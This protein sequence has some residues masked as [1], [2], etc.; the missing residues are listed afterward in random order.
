MGQRLTRR[1]QRVL[2]GGVR[3][4]VRGGHPPRDRGDVDDAPRSPLPHGRQHRLDH[5]DRAPVVGLEHRPVL[6]LGRELERRRPADARVVDEDVDGALALEGRGHRAIDRVPERHVQL[7]HH[8]RQLLRAGRVLERAR[9]REIAHGRDHPVAM[10]REVQ[11]GREADAGAGAGDE[12]NGHVVCSS[13]SGQCCAP[14][15][16][17]SSER[18]QAGERHGGRLAETFH[19]CLDRVRG[20]R[21]LRLAGTIPGRSGISGPAR[22]VS[23]GRGSP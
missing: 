9:L 2:G 12:G 1:G 8:E 23:I 22:T 3:D 11:R 21:V 18:P 6:G 5:A 19:L 14:A 10:A 4:L 16:S 20:R 15:G 7:A 13:S 17:A